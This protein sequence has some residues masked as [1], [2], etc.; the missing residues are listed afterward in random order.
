MQIH[1]LFIFMYYKSAEIDV[2]FDT[3]NKKIM[4]LDVKKKQN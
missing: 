4:K 1:K 2:I 3:M